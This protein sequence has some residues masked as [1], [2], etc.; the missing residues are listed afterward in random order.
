[1]KINDSVIRE[2]QWAAQNLNFALPYD[3]D[4][5]EEAILLLL[6]A[7]IHKI[8]DLEKRVGEIS[9]SLVK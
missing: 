3:V 6:L 1:M 8:A 4:Y 5:Q 9:N 2:I 7:A